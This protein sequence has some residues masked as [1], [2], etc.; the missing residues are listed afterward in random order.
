[1]S[2]EMKLKSLLPI[3]VVG[4]V[5]LF[6]INGTDYLDLYGKLSRNPMFGRDYLI[7]YNAVSMISQGI[8]DVYNQAFALKNCDK[9]GILPTQPLNYPPF[10]LLIYY[11]FA[12]LAPKAAISVMMVLNH[13]LLLLSVVLLLK[14]VDIKSYT[15]V[16]PVFIIALLSAPS[17]DS[18][19]AGQINFIILFLLSMFFYLYSREK[20]EWA[21]AALGMA[22]ALK[23]IP[24]VALLYFV[25]KKDYKS[26]AY[27][28]ASFLGFTFLPVL[29]WGNKILADYIAVRDRYLFVSMG[30][31]NQSVRAFFLKYFTANDMYS[32]V[33]NS[34]IFAVCGWLLVSTALIAV[35]WFVCKNRVGEGDKKISDLTGLASTLP[36]GLL[37]L[38][39]SWSHHSLWLIPAFIFGFVCL[40]NREGNFNQFA[41]FNCLILIY[42]IFDG[43]ISARYNILILK[44]Y[45]MLYHSG[46]LLNLAAFGFL[47]FIIKGMKIN[48]ETTNPPK[49]SGN[50]CQ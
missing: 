27:S 6:S 37:V 33:F 42:A 35:F 1:M 21:S 2:K 25:V 15:A 31:E 43:T 38:S 50:P 39:F 24:G 28:I 3:I 22:M 8:T 47:M 7:N 16:I 34:N 12:F 41:G 40:L 14:S 32:A 10:M 48:K 49:K 13:I 29:F 23:I 18:L 20:T 30:Y 4:L 9:L 44:N 46:M 26:L 36:L 5:F 11:P 19:F 45:P 17:V